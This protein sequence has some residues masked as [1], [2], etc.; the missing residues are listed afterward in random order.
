MNR[1]RRRPCSRSR[2]NLRLPAVPDRPNRQTTVC[3]RRTLPESSGR[4]RRLDRT[5][6]GLPD[7]V[8]GRFPG[9]D[10]AV[11]SACR[12]PSQSKSASDLRPLGHSTRRA[13][14]ARLLPWN[15]WIR[16]AAVS[17]GDRDCRNLRQCLLAGQPEFTVETWRIFRHRRWQ[18][19][20]GDRE[21][22][23]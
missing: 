20:P 5:E 21:L 12:P 22:S 8:R 4:I 13:I 10:L 2:R 19:N 18:A 11:P 17:P 9:S 14:P 15:W 23:S 3:G 16:I 6:P 7:C 1:P